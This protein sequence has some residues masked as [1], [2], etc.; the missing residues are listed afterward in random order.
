MSN[1][2]LAG[3]PPFLLLAPGITSSLYHQVLCAFD[4]A[5]KTF[6]VHTMIP[7]V[8]YTFFAATERKN[9]HDILT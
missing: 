5:P 4:D 9:N 7:V 8:K 1:H 2:V 6:E 3:T